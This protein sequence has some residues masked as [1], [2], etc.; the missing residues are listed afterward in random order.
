MFDGLD[1]VGDGL[2]QID[3]ISFGH[4]QIF[5]YFDEGSVSVCSLSVV[6]W[7]LEY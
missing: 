6:H 3:Q 1:G 2:P 7:F 4:H 5:V